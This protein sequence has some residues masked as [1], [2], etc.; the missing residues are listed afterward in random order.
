MNQSNPILMQG[1]TI[2]TTDITGPAMTLTKDNTL[3]INSG[4]TIQMGGV[5][6]TEDKL[7]RMEAAL[8]F[9]ERFAAENEEARAVWTAIK[10][11]RRILK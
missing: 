10:T 1:L 3:T 11:K 8:E 6:L 7:A 2:S 4:S 5:T 9:I